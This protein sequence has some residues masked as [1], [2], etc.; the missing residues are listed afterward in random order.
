LALTT[1]EA[2]EE[3]LELLSDFSGR[4][5]TLMDEAWKDLPPEVAEHLL[6]ASRAFADSF[7]KLKS[8]LEH[9]ELV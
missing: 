8:A 3:W 9:N 5:G 2:L 1:N 7:D 4:W 6:L